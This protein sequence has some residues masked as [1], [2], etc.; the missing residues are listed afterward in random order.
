MNLE[1]LQTF[2]R[3]D[4]S[5]RY[6]NSLLGF[7]WVFLRPFFIF[8]ILNVIFSVFGT[9]IE[10]YSAYLLCGIILFQFFSD[11]TNF[12]M[13]SLFQKAHLIP[14]V[15]FPRYLAVVASCL[16]ALMHVFFAILILF[17][18][19]F[20]QGIYPSFLSLLV[21]FDQITKFFA[22]FCL[23][24]DVIQVFSFFKLQLAQNTG[25]AFSIPVPGFIVVILTLLILIFLGREIFWK[26]QDDFLVLIAEILIFAGALGNLI[27][28][29]LL[30]SVTDFLAFWSFPIFN[31]A[32][33]FISVG[34]AI[35]IIFEIFGFDFLKKS[36]N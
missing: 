16:G 7:F 22:K 8:L 29:I 25:I 32:D 26:K 6:S 14:K 31:L 30:G 18:F 3:A 28:R 13:Y 34:V 5:L 12:G 27:D 36:L 21:S 15:N 1:I 11:G 17:G 33:C 24:E 20:F 9:S 10:N 2:I 4:F 35:F 19:L 23:Q